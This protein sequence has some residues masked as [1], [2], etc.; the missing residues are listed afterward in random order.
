[1]KNERRELLVSNKAFESIDFRAITY[2]KYRIIYFSVPPSVVVACDVDEWYAS[3]RKQADNQINARPLPSLELNSS[4]MA[5]AS[6][7]PAQTRRAST[8]QKCSTAT[9]CA[10]TS[11]VAETI[12]EENAATPARDERKGAQRQ[13]R[14]AP[15][16][17]WI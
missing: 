13:K 16:L 6:R 2:Y 14:T 5:C 11:C 8:T 4:A 7:S 15:L 9:W 1:M 10:S 12:S 17:P 3:T